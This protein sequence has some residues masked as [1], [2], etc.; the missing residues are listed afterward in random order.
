M[1]LT[2]VQQGSPNS[3]EHVRN[4]IVHDYNPR[5]DDGTTLLDKKTTLSGNDARGVFWTTP[6]HDHPP[7]AGVIDLD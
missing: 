2:I 7:A 3:A 5:C 6:V 4:S 1:P